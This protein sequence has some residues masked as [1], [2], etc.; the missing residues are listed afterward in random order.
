MGHVVKA[1]AAM[2]SLSAIIAGAI[3][4]LPHA[5]KYFEKAPPLAAAS[6]IPAGALARRAFDADAPTPTR[7]IEPQRSAAERKL[8]QAM[9]QPKADDGLSQIAMAAGGPS[10]QSTLGR[11][12]GQSAALAFADARTGG[13]SLDSAAEL[14]RRAKIQ[15]REGA[16]SSA[17]LLLTRAARAGSPEA[18][19]WLGQSYDAAALAELG[20][21]GVRSDAAAARKYYEQAVA[22]GS[23]DARTRLAKLGQ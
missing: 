15:L 9:A 13:E 1:G 21:K 20:V 17:R 19:T 22:A 14:I 5:S 4:S 16:A 23:P 10:D 11:P 8:A 3:A 6:S 12:V 2:V 7:S 18:L